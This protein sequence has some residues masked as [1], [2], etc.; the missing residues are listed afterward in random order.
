MKPQ[1]TRRSC[2]L[3]N[4]CE[5]QY[6]PSPYM[7]VM[8]NDVYIATYVVLYAGEKVECSCPCHGQI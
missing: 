3:M 6:A 8:K 2:F 7:S 1:H 5:H 4:T